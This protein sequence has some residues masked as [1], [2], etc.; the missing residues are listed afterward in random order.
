MKNKNKQNESKTEILWAKECTEKEAKN[1]INTDPLGS[2]TGVPTDDPNEKP[3]QDA[4][5]L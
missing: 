4:D 1:E 2:Y 3:I 5:D